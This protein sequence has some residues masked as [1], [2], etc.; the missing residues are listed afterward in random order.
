MH[1]VNKH[2]KSI[3][4]EEIAEQFVDLVEQK[5][6]EIQTLIK[7]EP[8]NLT[9]QIKSSPILRDELI[10][11]INK[12]EE[13]QQLSKLNKEL[14]QYI[15]KTFEYIRM[16]GKG[17]EAIVLLIKDS[18]D[19]PSILKIARPKLSGKKRGAVW[20]FSLRRFHIEHTDQTIKQRFIRGAKLQRELSGATEYGYIP[21]I[22]NIMDNPLCIQMEFSPAIKFHKFVKDNDLGTLLSFFVNLL[23]FVNEI[24]SYGVIHRDLKPDNILID[25]NNIPVLLDFTTSKQLAIEDNLTGVGYQIGTKVWSSP[26]QMLDA[27]K[28]TYQD[29]IFS[30]GLL[31]YVV[32]TKKNPEPLAKIDTKTQDLIILEDLGTTKGKTAF[33]NRLLIDIPEKWQEIFKKATAINEKNRYNVLE[34]FILAMKK[35]L[36]AYESTIQKKTDNLMGDTIQG[37]SK[38]YLELI[39]KVNIIEKQIKKISILIEEYFKNE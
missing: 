26:R 20:S 3:V 39:D 9:T 21:Q 30:L 7:P 15:N 24:H 18:L 11:K 29:D 32:L 31:F 23:I 33:I 28:S 27:G 16:I 38:Q 22:Y 1:P 6:K 17:G 35:K 4:K 2:R 5:G 10:R 12:T 14:L 8:L 36:N 34:D 25:K 19:S 37:T 13:I